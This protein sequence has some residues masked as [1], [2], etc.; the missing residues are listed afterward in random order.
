MPPRINR[1]GHRILLHRNTRLHPLLITLV[2][3]L[4]RRLIT[5]HLRRALGRRNAVL[6]LGVLSITRL[7]LRRRQLVRRHR[8]RK[9]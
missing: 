2:T 3:L 5:R 7:L 6:L 4:L 9:V 1:R 8:W